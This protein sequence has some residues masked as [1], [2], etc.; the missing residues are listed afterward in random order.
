MR[1]G[2][3]LGMCAYLK[4]FGMIFMIIECIKGE[5]VRFRQIWRKFR[6]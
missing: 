1:L 3:V 6:F 5:F 4:G 2:L